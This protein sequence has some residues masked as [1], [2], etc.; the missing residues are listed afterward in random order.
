[1]LLKERAAVCK[2]QSRAVQFFITKVGS[3]A[4]ELANNQDGLGLPALS[5][6]AGRLHVLHGLPELQREVGLALG[7]ETLQEFLM[8]V[9]PENILKHSV[10]ATGE[11]E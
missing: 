8:A 3:L 7:Q 4:E 1:M 11:D 2:H 10:K 5:V 6:T 9:V